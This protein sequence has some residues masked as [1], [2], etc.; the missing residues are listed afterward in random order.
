MEDEAFE[1]VFHIASIRFLPKIR[2]V[3]LR[4]SARWALARGT[5]PDNQP[6][7]HFEGL[8]S[9]PLYT[10]NNGDTILLFPNQ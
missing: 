2:S 7:R 3:S 6:T 8:L 1:H 9:M 4:T 5:G 10:P